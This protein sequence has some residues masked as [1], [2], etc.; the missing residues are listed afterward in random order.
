MSKLLHI[1]QS[2]F[3]TS[4]DTITAALVIPALHV[5]GPVAFHVG[6]QEVSQR[7]KDMAWI[8]LSVFLLSLPGSGEAAY[9]CVCFVQYS[10]LNTVLPL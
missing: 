1:A 2:Y 4:C 9:V 6:K 3:V 10:M 5:L 8:L 7:D